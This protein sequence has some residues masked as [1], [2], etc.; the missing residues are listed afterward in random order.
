MN[1]PTILTGSR[2]YLAKLLSLCET[3]V[4]TAR[5]TLHQIS[6]RASRRVLPSQIQCEPMVA[7]TGVLPAQWSAVLPTA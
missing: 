5:V 2:V 7:L 4:A 3:A 1:Q 6:P